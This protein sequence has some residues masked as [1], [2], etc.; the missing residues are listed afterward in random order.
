MKKCCLIIGLLAITLPGIG[1][2]VLKSKEPIPQAAITEIYALGET[3]SWL[4]GEYVEV[5]AVQE[6][7]DSCYIMIYVKS[8]PEKV[9]TP[10]E[11]LDKARVFTSTFLK[12]AVKVLDRHKI[13][14]DVSVWAQ[15]PLTEGGVDILGHSRYVAKDG[16][17][18]DFERFERTK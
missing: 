11:I 18:H 13:K 7:P 10:E 4:Y 9:T 17:F 15:F 6:R 12:S 1:C 8:L 5:K 14:R 16:S 2:D 3:R